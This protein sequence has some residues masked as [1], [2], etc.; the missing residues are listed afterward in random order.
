MNTRINH[1]KLLQL[2]GLFTW[3]M[4]GIPLIYAWQQGVADNGLLSESLSGWVFSFLAFG[5]LYILV[6]G[7]LNLYRRGW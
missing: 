3:V 5:L 7:N 6:S 4:V 1:Q 2:T